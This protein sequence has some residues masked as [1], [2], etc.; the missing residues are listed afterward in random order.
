MQYL[1]CSVFIMSQCLLLERS[2]SNE[3]G[4]K[5]KRTFCPVSVLETEVEDN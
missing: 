3:I 2:Q 4:R 5:Q 1:K